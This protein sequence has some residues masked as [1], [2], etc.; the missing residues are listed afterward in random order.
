MEK[1]YC[2]GREVLFF[3]FYWL[4]F[5]IAL[6]P[7]PVRAENN[8]DGNSVSCVQGYHADPLM[9]RAQ[10]EFTRG[11]FDKALRLWQEVETQCH[12]DGKTGPH[13][14]ILLQMADAWQEMGYYPLA[15]EKL[16]LALEL[17][18][19]L[20]DQR[21]L[22]MVEGSLGR[23]HLAV[24]AIDHARERLETALSMAE[25]TGDAA[26]TASVL[27]DFGALFTA[28][29]ALFKAS[30]AYERCAELSRQAGRQTLLV[31]ALLNMT[32][33]FFEQINYRE[34]MRFLEVAQKEAIRLKDTHEK[35]MTLA[36]VGKQLIALLE[37]SQY[38]GST[39]EEILLAAYEALKASEKVAGR[40]D[41]FAA[42]SYALGYLGQLY[43]IRQRYGDALHFTR[44]AIH[45][46]Q[47]TGLSDI[48]YRWQW[49][50]GRILAATGEN[51]GA[52]SAYRR[53]IHTLQLIRED[54]AAHCYRYRNQHLS[55]RKEV[56][57]VY[58]E[59]ADLLLKRSA[60]TD[61]SQQVKADLLEAR[62]TIEKFKTVELEEYFQDD[63][64]AR[65][66]TK[67][68]D[69]DNISKN[70]AI[71]YPVLLPDRLEILVTMP[72]GM[73]QYTVAVGA[74][75]VEAQIRRLRKELEDPHTTNYTLFANRL[76]NW[77]IHPMEKDL[78][79]QKIQTLVFVPDGGLRTI[80]LGALH[81][82]EKFLISKYAVV[83]THSLTL[84]DPRPLERGNF[85]L[86]VSGL[87]EP[88]QGYAPL[89]NVNFEL[90]TLRELYPGKILK[91]NDFTSKNIEESL[92]SYPY[93]IVHMA[94]HGNFDRDFRKTFILTYKEKLTMDI[95]G[96]LMRLNRSSKKPVELLTLSACKTAAGDD[97]AALGLAGVAIRAGARSVL[98]SLWYIQDRATSRLI[99]DFYAKLKNPAV[100]KARALQLS[101]MSL[102]EDPRYSHP[103][104][105]APFLMIGNWL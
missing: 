9:T 87:T 31:K 4:A 42:S 23:Y 44:R 100:S 102:L 105:W 43:E 77:L 86:L 97:R 88:V 21:I 93:T 19:K 70:T 82:G 98:A 78:A 26:L 66:K 99:A 64:V 38:T 51:E 81:D 57:S 74:R 20:D 2:F 67:E 18:E 13:I 56:G 61:S 29:Q 49:Q 3:V 35:A 60:M 83:T 6:T 24:G 37:F 10:A 25:K 52:I 90:K 32:R 91:D 41:D 79:K 72:D 53:T 28:E 47:K 14:E 92:K 1:K 39:D 5:T 62:S 22:L 96:K 50:T 73:K 15:K 33:I 103:A 27:N 11:K 59:L 34:S 84:T 30:K 71:I 95:L 104:Y 68:K 36:A 40:L 76:Y 94:S 89:P 45:A 85:Q 17:A 75:Y 69:L 12:T 7:H 55:F 63:C 8:S 101:Q 16:T 48:L 54:V 58:F 65:L 80:P 46:A